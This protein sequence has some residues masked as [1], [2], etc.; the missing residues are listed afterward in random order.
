MNKYK[1]YLAG[2][3]SVTIESDLDLYDFTKDITKSKIYLI[4]GKASIF[5]NK[6]TMI[7][8]L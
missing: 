8:K 3:N 4:V 7:E 1:I 5:V 6:I 2:G